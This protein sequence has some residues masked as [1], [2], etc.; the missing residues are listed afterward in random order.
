MQKNIVLTILLVVAIGSCSIDSSMKGKTT[1][2]ATKVDLG[3]SED[4]VSIDWLPQVGLVA[5]I[6]DNNEYIYGYRKENDLTLYPLYLPDDLPCTKGADYAYLGHLPDMRLG[7]TKYCKRSENF[8]NESSAYL[9]A[10]EL[11]THEILP[12]VKAPLPYYASYFSWNPEMSRGVMQ[13]YQTVAGTIFWITSEGGA[14]MDVVVGD[15]KR[16]WSLAVD[17][18]NWAQDQPKGIAAY[19][20]WSPNGSVI[21]FFASTDAIERSG[22]AR[23]SSK[24]NIYFMDPEE[25][26]PRPVLDGIYHPMQLKW[27]PDGKWLAFIGKMGLPSKDGIWIFSPDESKAII[28]ASGDYRDIVWSP[29]GSSLIAMLCPKKVEEDPFCKAAEFWEFDVSTL[30][31]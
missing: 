22:L 24:F 19:P 27:S 1:I 15:G 30:L 28:V 2:M 29:G 31:E 5:F 4:V 3:P 13:I 6:V 26:K 16:A 10:Y 9:V 25:Q 18:P 12:L 21:A 8:P 11:H 14:P 20:A 7:F 17:Y 23:A